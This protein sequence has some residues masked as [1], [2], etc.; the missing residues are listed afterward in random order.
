MIGSADESRGGEALVY[1]RSQ[2][3]KLGPATEILDGFLS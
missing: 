3:K 2:V 1:R